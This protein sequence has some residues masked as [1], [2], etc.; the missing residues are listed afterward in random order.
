ME[1]TLTGHVR[2]SIDAAEAGRSR[3]DEHAFAVPAMSGVKIRHLLNNLGSCDHL[4]HLEVGCHK[5]GTLVAANYGNQML[6]SHA[7]DNWSGFAQEGVS[8]REF[9]RWTS[10]LLPRCRLTVCEQDFATLTQIEVPDPIGFYFYDGDHSEAASRAALTTLY[11]LLADE[12]VYCVDDWNW[13]GP[14]NGT[15]QAVAAWGW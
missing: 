15:V 12:F 14:K 2:R 3:M 4:R 10:E 9:L 6:S 1:S 7:V 13:D 8:R 11:P 5:G